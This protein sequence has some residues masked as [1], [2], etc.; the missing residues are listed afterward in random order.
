MV[1]SFHFPGRPLEQQGRL[2]SWRRFRLP[3]KTLLTRP[4]TH[5]LRTMVSIQGWFSKG[6]PTRPH[7]LR[8]IVNEVCGPA[9]PDIERK[10]CRDGPE[11]ADTT[12]PSGSVVCE[13]VVNLPPAS[14]PSENL[15]SNTGAAPRPFRS[16]P[17]PAER[18]KNR[19]VAS[20][21]GLSEWASFIVGYS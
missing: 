14:A 3:R 10:A 7:R 13:I 19:P 6:K 15:L 2:R 4:S 9:S 21:V 8:T 1:T 17:V 5:R 20:A 18:E 16:R 11:G 12:F